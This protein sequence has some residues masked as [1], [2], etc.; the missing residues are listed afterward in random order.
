MEKRLCRLEE[1][2]TF[3][4]HYSLRINQLDPLRKEYEALVKDYLNLPSEVKQLPDIYLK[5]RIIYESDNNHYRIVYVWGRWNLYD[6]TEYIKDA[7]IEFLEGK[8]V[9]VSFPHVGS[10]THGKV[11]QYTFNIKLDQ[12]QPKPETPKKVSGFRVASPEEVMKQIQDTLSPGDIEA[13]KNGPL[14]TSLARKDS[15]TAII[16]HG[17][18]NNNF[19]MKWLR[20]KQ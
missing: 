5:T 18:I 10:E 8:P 7:K 16:K 1:M 13:T 15:K 4:E 14:N 12:E 9:K 11:V 3:P 20:R 2:I 19:I 6:G 17:G